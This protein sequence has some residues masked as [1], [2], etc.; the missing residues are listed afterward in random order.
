MALLCLAVMS[1]SLPWTFAFLC[2]ADAC[3]FSGSRKMPG[4]FRGAAFAL[5][6]SRAGRVRG[7]KRLRHLQRPDARCT[8]RCRTP[9]PRRAGNCPR[10]CWARRLRR[11]CFSPPFTGLAC[12]LSKNR[13][14]LFTADAVRRAAGV[15]S[16]RWR[17]W[18]QCWLRRWTTALHSG[19]RWQPSARWPCAPYW[20]T[21]QKQAAGAAAAACSAGALL[22]SA[23]NNFQAGALF[24][25]SLLPACALALAAAGSVEKS[26]GTTMFEKLGRARFAMP[27][28]HLAAMLAALSIAGLPPFSGFYALKAGLNALSAAQ[29]PLGLTLFLLCRPAVRRGGRARLPSGF[30]RRAER[31]L[32]RNSRGSPSAGTGGADTAVVRGAVLRLAFRTA[33]SAAA[34]AGPAARRRTGKP[35]WP[36]FQPHCW[37]PG[38]WYRKFFYQ[39]RWRWQRKASRR[40]PAEMAAWALELRPLALAAQGLLSGGIWLCGA[41]EKPDIGRKA[42]GATLMN[43]FNAFLAVPLTGALVTALLPDSKPGLAGRAAALFSGAA[44]P[45]GRAGPH[46]R[47][48]DS[49][50]TGPAGAGAAALAHSRARVCGGT[51]GLSG[52]S[53]RPRA[54]RCGGKARPLLC[55]TAYSAGRAGGKLLLLRLALATVLDCFPPPPHICSC[56][57][58][59]RAAACLEFITHC[60]ACSARWELPGCLSSSPAP[61][62]TPHCWRRPP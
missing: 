55:P 56:A 1:A 3:A 4:A 15:V 7:G 36:P 61:G 8:A 43:V 29:Q 47:R 30:Q 28:T 41:L 49:P 19:R 13:F 31:R 62:P 2:C 22:L 52:R 38:R 59:E 44:F 26:F 6:A 51:A 21:T 46:S 45:D 58:A 57:Q 39:T 18:S 25:F 32:A 16:P 42:G 50:V 27:I 37:R 17:G 53:G 9:A 34:D 11:A 35:C 20:R 10:G 12:A 40:R 23:L 33:R 48:Q 60:P 5:P 54:V 14:R 24:L